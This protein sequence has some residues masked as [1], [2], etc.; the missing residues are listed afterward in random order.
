MSKDQAAKIAEREYATDQHSE[1]HE[2]AR[3]NAYRPRL[4]RAI[5]RAMQTTATTAMLAERARIMGDLDAVLMRLGPKSKEYAAV[6]MVRNAI[7]GPMSAAPTKGT[8]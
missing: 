6:M 4:E 1:D 8:M 3:A 5:R 2:V 7:Q